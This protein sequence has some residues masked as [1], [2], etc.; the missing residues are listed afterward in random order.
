MSLST[1]ESEYMVLATRVKDAVSNFLEELGY[2]C[3]PLPIMMDNQSTIQLVSNPELYRRIKYLDVRYHF[4][5]GIARRGDILIDYVPT[6]KNISDIFKNLAKNQ[7]SKLCSMLRLS[8]NVRASGDV[9]SGA[10]NIALAS[11]RRGS[12]TT[13]SAL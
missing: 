13:E 1:T 12:D 9:E 10:S 5:R 6:E 11:S 8:R 2:K 4:V 3:K 7:I